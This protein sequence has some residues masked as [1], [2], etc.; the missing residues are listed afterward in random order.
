MKIKIALIVG[1]LFFLSAC[2]SAA[3]TDLSSVEFQNKT[4]EAGVVTLDVRTPGEFFA[5]HLE[6]AINIDVEGMGFAE[7]VAELDKSKTYAVYC[8]SGRRSA[9]ALKILKDAGIAS[10]FNLK[11]GILDWNSKGLPTVKN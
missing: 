1:A 11:N 9:I 3:A 5:G 7:A 6:N 2:S 8:Q 10:T 4:K